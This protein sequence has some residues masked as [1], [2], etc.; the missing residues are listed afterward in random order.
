MNKCN[1]RRWKHENGGVLKYQDPA[2]TLN[3][4][5]GSVYGGELEPVIIK[6]AP[7]KA[8]LNTYYPIVSKYP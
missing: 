5:E 4:P 3:L 6:P 8:E 1:T 7:I 2:T